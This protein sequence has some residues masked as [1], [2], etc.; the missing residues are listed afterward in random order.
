MVAGRPRDPYQQFR[1]TIDFD[2]IG[3]ARYE[4]GSE[5][6]CEIGEA[7]YWEGGS[8]V[9]E[10]LPGR[11]T[12]PNITLTRGASNDFDLYDWARS[13]ANASSGRGKI[14]RRN[15]TYKQMKYDSDPGEYFHVF[16][17]QHRKWSSGPWDNTTD[18]VR[19]ESTELSYKYFEREAA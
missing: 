7:V 18:E 3:S 8:L 2:G 9:P 12:F 11:L 19:I 10:K 13:T 17:A 14:D 5:L 1:F 15:G 4:K 16:D 6:V